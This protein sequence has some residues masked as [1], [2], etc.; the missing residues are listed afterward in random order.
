MIGNIRQAILAIT[1]RAQASE[2]AET[3]RKVRGLAASLFRKPAEIAAKLQSLSDIMAK[4]ERETSSWVTFEQFAAGERGPFD[5]CD[6]RIWLAL[7]EECG[8][9]A[10][11]A[12]EILRLT[13]DEMSRLSGSVKMPED[14]VTKGI[15]RRAEA[16]LKAAG[17]DVAETAADAKIDGAELNERLF[18]VM[19]NVPNGWMVR[20]A[21]CGSIELK[22][23]A[24][25]GL[26]GSTAPEIRFGN[27]LEIGPGWI[28]SGNRRRVNVSD[29]RTVSSYAEGPG[30]DAVFLARP[31][32][33][34]ARYFVG[35]DP[36]RH[37]TPFQGKGIWPAE[38]RAFVEGGVVVGVSSYYGWCGE[39][40]AENARVA[41]EVRELAQRIADRAAGSSMF[42]RYMDVEFARMNEHLSVKGNE[43][44]QEAL[45]IFGRDTVACTLD[46][47]ETKDGGLM[48]LE[49]GPPNTPFGGGHPCSFAG[50]GGQPKFGN[51]TSVEGAAFKL[52][53]H[54]ILADPS[55]W[56]DGER[57]GCILSW[58]EVKNLDLDDRA[59]P[60]LV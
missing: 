33:E 32:M 3:V 24:G 9:P 31:W 12:H 34:S 29:T 38:W 14:R 49:G 53:P 55:T 17:E 37:G 4:H 1:A 39:V 46:F 22:S 40:T 36:H 15:R 50:C 19:D 45:A 6:L 27:D 5:A 16:Y 44:I 42:P 23:L 35:P 11:P 2:R 59:A 8:V 60:G 28:R 52:M 18:A 25:A 21:R 57:S 56:D 13:E 51:R 7:A 43:A 54:V 10:V 47:I 26:A 58:E 48:L 41:M 30:G 20:S